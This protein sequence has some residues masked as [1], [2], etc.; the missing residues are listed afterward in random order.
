MRMVLLTSGLVILFTCAMFVTYEVVTFKQT[1]ARQLNILGKAIAQNSTAALAFDNAERRARGARGVQ[2]GSAHRVGG[3]VRQ[4]RRAVRVVSGRHRARRPA[5]Q[6]AGGWLPFRGR[7]TSSASSPCSSNGEVLGTL[8][9][10]SDLQAIDRALRGYALI[11][12]LV[13]AL[14]VL[15]AYFVA[16][17]AAVAR[18]RGRCWSSPRPRARYPTSTTTACARNPRARRKSTQ[19]TDAFNHMLTQIQHSEIRSRAQMQRL[20][21]LQHI[22]GA[23]GDR[24]DLPSI[25]QVVLRNV[26]ENLPVDFGCVCLYDAASATLTVSTVG[27]ASRELAP[28]LGLAE[29]AVGAHRRERPVDAA[30]AAGWSTNPTRANS[31]FPFPQRFATSGLFSLVI[32]PLQVEASVF[33]VFIAARR[34]PDAFS[35]GDCEFLM[36]LSGHV[37]LASHQARLHGALAAG[38]RRPAPVAAHGHAAGAPAR[39]RADGERHRARHQQRDFAD[40]AVYRL[41]AGT[42]AE[43]DREGREPRSR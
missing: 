26:E 14:A 37:A 6:A 10:K 30:F 16:R 22:T 7:G 21:L 23:I 32:A 38:V 35:S 33:G 15:L 8:F 12:A 2:R 27:V 3:A 4:V 31:P 39:A 13:I 25:F 29:R 40:L 42:R 18:S 5:G 9:V 20:S 34:A 24:Q 36:Q 43:P 11:T 19:L 1:V 17:T 41:A 28:A